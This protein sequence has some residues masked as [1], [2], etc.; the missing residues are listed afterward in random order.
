MSEKQRTDAEALALSGT[1]VGPGVVIPV[2]YEK[3]WLADFYRVLAR[4]A[5][6]A[7]PAASLEVYLDDSAPLRI[8]VRPGHVADGDTMYSYVGCDD[9]AVLNNIDNYVYLTS[10]D[11]AAGNS[12]TINQTDFPDPSVTP[13]IPLAVVTALGG[14]VTIDAIAARRARALVRLLAGM[15]AAAAN[16]LT[17]GSN[18][19]TLH[20]HAADGITNGTITDE[21]MAVRYLSRPATTAF[22]AIYFTDRPVDGQLI[23]ID[24]YKFE[25]DTDNAFPES[26]GD[27][28]LDCNGNTTLAQDI[29]DIANGI[30]AA[31][32][33]VTAYAD[34]VNGAIWIDA[35]VPGTAG[36]A[37]TLATTATHTTVSGAH[38]ADGSEATPAATYHVRHLV[39]AAEAAAGAI[40]VRTSL[41]SMIGA[42]V[43]MEDGGVAVAIGA[44]VILNVPY[45]T[46]VAITPAWTAGDCIEVWATGGP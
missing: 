25:Y 43:T 8:G 30:N 20:T 2:A 41:D 7:A 13:H 26:G 34:A 27:Y 21:K 22:G 36:N 14:A 16:T 10:A 17:G 38:L 37:I 3:P 11:L 4:L 29:V 35:N 12:V 15:T 32:I 24:G 5:D 1:A 9:Q 6:S 45:I 19:D 31:G 39:T 44:S 28:I 18:A 42:I 46:I 33:T 40:R 23:T